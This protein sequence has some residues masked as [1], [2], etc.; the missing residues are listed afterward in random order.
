[1]QFS[2]IPITKLLTIDTKCTRRRKVASHLVDFIQFSRAEFV[3][4]C[5]KVEKTIA[6]MPEFFSLHLTVFSLLCVRFLLTVSNESELGESW[7]L[8]KVWS[9]S[10]VSISKFFK[11]CGTMISMVEEYDHYSNFLPWMTVIID[12]YDRWIIAG[13]ISGVVLRGGPK[14]IKWAT[15]IFRTLWKI[16]QISCF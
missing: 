10:Y 9:I 7:K 6:R 15:D 11:N 16:S 5:G 4:I 8:R 12:F 14:H 2:S 1:M 3:E 13:C